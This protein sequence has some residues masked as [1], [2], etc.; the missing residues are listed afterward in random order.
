MAPKLAGEGYVGYIDINCIVNNNGIYPL[1]FT[2]ALRVSDDLHPAGGHDHADRH[3]PRRPRARPRPE[4]QG[5]ERIPG[6]RADRHAALP[7]R[8][9]ADL[10]GVHE[11]RRIVFKRGTPEEVHIEDTKIVE[12]QWLVAG[13]S[14]VVLTV[15]GLGQTM[16]Q[17]REQAYSRVRN[18]LIPNM[19]YRDDI[20]E[21]WAEDSR[22][23]PQLGIPEVGA[24]TGASSSPV[25]AERPSLR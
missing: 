22:Q 1:E 17:A 10:R 25:E 15:V 20:G 3:L 4:A 7:L 23:A 24:I 6:R 16:K 13:S 11:E 12:G 5:Q 9:H 2:V 18:I 21:R 14:G 19:Y 8:R